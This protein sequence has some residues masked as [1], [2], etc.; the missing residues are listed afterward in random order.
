MTLNSRAIF[1]GIFAA[2]LL[3]ELDPGHAAR[4]PAPLEHRQSRGSLFEWSP[5]VQQV[6][7][8]LIEFDLLAGPANKIGRAHV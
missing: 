7:Q 4:T 1:L 6:Q 5:L 2:S 8:L 3:L